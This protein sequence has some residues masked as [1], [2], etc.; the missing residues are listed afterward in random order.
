MTGDATPAESTESTRGETGGPTED[1]QT[2]DRRSGDRLAGDSGTDNPEPGDPQAGD[3]ETAGE[4]GGMTRRSFVRAAGGTAAA[5]GA[6]AAVGA[7]EAAAQSETY[8]FGGEVAAWHGRAPAAIEG[9]D[10]P[11]IEL[12]AGTEYEFWFENID[13]APHNITMQDSEGNTIAQSSLVSSEGATAS[14][15]FTATPQMTQY[16]CTIH[17]TTM[18]GD[19]EVTGELEG[20]G[21][22]IPT[23]MLV[24]AA[25][26]VLAFISPLLFALFLFS[27]DREA[28]GETTA[29]P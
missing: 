23:R 5:A 18:V 20:G 14:V 11:T 28:G 12:E 24:L 17:P 4:G 21:G 10:N 13:G 27:R 16:I 8:R 9:Q 29:R 6:A 26:V 25:G 22:G 2:A 1:Q 15:T 3:R 7:D 19:V